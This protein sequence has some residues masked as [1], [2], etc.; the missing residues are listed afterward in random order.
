[1]PVASHPA[2]T[3]GRSALWEGRARLRSDNRKP[4]TP[5]RPN[6]L[7]MRD[8]VSVVGMLVLIVACHH[9]AAP[10][11]DVTRSSPT[12]AGRPRRR[13]HGCGGAV[14]RNRW[15]GWRLGFWPGSLSPVGGFRGR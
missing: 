2:P 1:A 15:A 13:P 10:R 6:A 11:R 5:R 8:S 12:D 4:R 9:I 14:P 7:M 3:L